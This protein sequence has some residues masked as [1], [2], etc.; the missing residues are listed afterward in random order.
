[1]A[2][3]VKVYCTNY[4]RAAEDFNTRE[5]VDS[6]IDNYSIKNWS[7]SVKQY[8]REF[9]VSFE[10]YYGEKYMSSINKSFAEAF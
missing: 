2:Y 5:E 9:G 6:F 3:K 8:V 4:L 1:M 7:N 10:I